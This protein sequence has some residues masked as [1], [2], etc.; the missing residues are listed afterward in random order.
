MADTISPTF[1]AIPCAPPDA[2][3]S[4]PA[5]ASMWEATSRI[6]ESIW[7]M[8]VEVSRA[9]SARCPTLW[10]TSRADTA[11]DA[12]R[13]AAVAGKLF[14]EDAARTT[15]RAKTIDSGKAAKIARLEAEGNN[16]KAKV[17]GS[18]GS[19]LAKKAKPAP[20]G[21][22]I[23]KGKA[24]AKVKSKAAAKASKGGKRK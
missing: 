20:G 21:G 10:A 14:P 17:S 5:R 8:E 7:T 3:S 9:R 1:D 6:E 12:A 23:G 24:T 4:E 16:R 2:L 22:G 18:G 13:T 15:V 11:A 19:K